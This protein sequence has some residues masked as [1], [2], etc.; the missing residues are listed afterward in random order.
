[1]RH[2]RNVATGS[3]PAAMA[4]C[5]L[6]RGWEV[7]HLHGPGAVIPGTLTESWPLLAEGEALDHQGLQREM[8]ALADTVLDELVGALTGP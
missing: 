7:H 6:E 4:E 2:I 3:L 8:Q 1:M 5:L